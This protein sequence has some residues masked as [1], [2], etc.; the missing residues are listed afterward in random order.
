MAFYCFR[1]DFTFFSYYAV[2]GYTEKAPDFTAKSG[3]FSVENAQNTGKVH[4]DKAPVR[5]LLPQLLTVGLSWFEV[6]LPCRGFQPWAVISNSEP[7]RATSCLPNS[8]F[9]MCP[10]SFTPSIFSIL[11]W[12]PMG[13]V[14]SNS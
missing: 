13:T 6:Y 12:S 4:G 1:S 8:G 5:D 11:A 2:T 7:S 9:V 10:M 3:A 14:N